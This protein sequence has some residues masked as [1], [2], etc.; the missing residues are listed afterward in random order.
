MAAANRPIEILWR[1]VKYRWLN[2]GHYKTWARLKKAILA[3]FKQFGEKYTINFSEL[4]TKNT[5]K[6]IKF[7]SA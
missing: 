3:I 7:N 5:L 1:F 4:I 2:K 6:N